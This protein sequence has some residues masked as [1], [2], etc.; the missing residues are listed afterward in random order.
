MKTTL[1]ACALLVLT[2]TAPNA[3]SE[4]KMSDGDASFAAK[5]HGK[6]RA[7][8][9]N[10]FYS[11]ASVRIA[12]A[13]AAA[14]ARGE[15]AAELHRGLELP[16]GDAAH[17]AF[18]Q[19]LASWAALAVPPRP[20]TTPADPELQKWQQQELEQK[21]VVLR[22]VNRL[23][24]QAGHSF[25]EAFTKR[26]RD[27]YQAPLGSVDFH[28]DREAARAAINKWVSDA[29]EHKIRELLARG[30]ISGETKLILTNAVYFKAHWQDEFA[31]AATEEQPFFAA[32]GHTVHAPLMRRI[33]Y[34]KLARSDGATMAELPYGDGRLVMDAVLPDGRDGLGHVEE[35]YAEGGLAKWTAALRST[36]TEVM[37]PRFRASSSFELAAELSALGMARAFHFPAADFSGMDGTHELFI[38]SVVHQAFVNVDEHGTEAAAATAVMMSAGAAPPSEKPV[39]FRADHPFLF[40]V[41]DTQNGA[42]LF[43]GRLADP[44]QK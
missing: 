34:V 2:A 8:A 41:R 43:A 42:V 23:W 33:G 19:Q 11:P 44:S 35:A 5:L 30:T 31:A 26:L 7:H 20:S 10:L 40:L 3:R 12:M 15:T 18:K 14:G 22:V 28:H 17:A 13:M 39:V 38:G 6:L 32:G 4:T 37:L 1:A 24:A 9:G 21:R 25:Q 29:T 16:A 27:D 36:R